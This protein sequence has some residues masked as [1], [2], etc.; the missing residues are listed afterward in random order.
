MTRSARVLAVDDDPV[1]LDVFTEFLQV[2]GYETFTATNTEH[3]VRLLA[4]TRPH[5]VLL[6]MAIAHSDGMTILR[7]IR[8]Q[9]PE[10]PVIMVTANPDPDLMRDPL[11]L[12]AFQYIAKPFDYV[13]LADAIAAALASRRV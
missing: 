9:Y 11:Q 8:T 12:G 10:I 13:H 4:A 2:Q 5:V 1:I 7:K 6:D 3:A